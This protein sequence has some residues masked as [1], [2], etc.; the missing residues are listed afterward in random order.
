MRMLVDRLAPIV[1]QT[2]GMTRA[3]FDHYDDSIGEEPV[4]AA[5]AEQLSPR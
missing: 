3:Y 1:T 5:I 2:I 4:V